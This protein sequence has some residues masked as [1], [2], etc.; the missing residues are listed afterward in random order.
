[1]EEEEAEYGRTSGGGET[2]LHAAGGDDREKKGLG[3]SLV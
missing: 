3:C 2:E 1:M